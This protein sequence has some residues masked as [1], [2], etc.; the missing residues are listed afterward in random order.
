MGTAHCGESQTSGKAGG[1]K[2]VNR[3]KRLKTWCHLKV[4]ITQTDSADP[5]DGLLPLALG[6]ISEPSP[7]PYQPSK[8]NSLLPKTVHPSRSLYAHETSGQRRSR[9]SPSCNQPPETPHI[10]G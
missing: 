2:T 3:S 7:H 5:T 10:S 6:C 9:F 8:H 1:L 4:A